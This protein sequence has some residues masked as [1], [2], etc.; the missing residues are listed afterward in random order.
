MNVKSV[1]WVPGQQSFW[2]NPRTK[3]FHDVVI[4]VQHLQNLN[5]HSLFHYF[6]PL[7]ENARLF[8][9]KYLFRRH[10]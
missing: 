7:S 5:Y 8:Y 4:A 9:S 6:D 1:D 10:N 2:Q 3:L